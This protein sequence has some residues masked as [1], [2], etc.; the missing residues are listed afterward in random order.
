MKDNISQLMMDAMPGLLPASLVCIVVLVVF[1]FHVSSICRSGRVACTEIFCPRQGWHCLFAVTTSWLYCSD[2]YNFMPLYQVVHT[3]ES[4]VEREAFS[5]LDA[6]FGWLSFLVPN[7]YCY[8]V[9]TTVHFVWI[10]LPRSADNPDKCANWA[11]KGMRCKQLCGKLPR[12]NGPWT[13]D[14]WTNRQSRLVL[15]LLH[16]MQFHTCN[17]WYEHCVLNCSF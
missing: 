13:S 11:G 10:G 2:L 17:S 12:L 14:S 5:W 15:S 7:V 6:M 4:N 16:Y 8:W 1:T 3:M 9:A